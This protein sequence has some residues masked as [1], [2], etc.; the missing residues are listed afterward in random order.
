MSATSC[1]T[2]PSKMSFLSGQSEGNLLVGT[3][4]CFRKGGF[5]LEACHSLI[6]E[7]VI[8]RGGAL[9]SCRKMQQGVESPRCRYC[10]R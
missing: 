1:Y 9:G 7:S 2:I 4:L 10:V 8:C 5:W 6:S 3:C